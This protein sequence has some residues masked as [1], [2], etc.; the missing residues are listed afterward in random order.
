[1]HYILQIVALALMSLGFSSQL[2][3]SPWT[4]YPDRLRCEYLK[5]PL[6]IDALRPRLSWELQ[7]LSPATRSQKQTAYQIIVASTELFLKQNLGDLWDSG[8]IHSDQSIHVPYGGKP[9]LSHQVCWW[10]LR[11][12]DEVDRVSD[13]SSPSFWTMGLLR[14]EEWKARWIGFDGGEKPMEFNEL[15]RASWIRHPGSRLGSHSAGS[16]NLFP[17]SVRDPKRQNSHSA[18]LRHGRSRQFQSLCQ[19]P[20]VNFGFD[21]KSVEFS[22]WSKIVD[23]L[24]FKENWG[25]VVEINVLQ[26]GTNVLAVA[27]R[28]PKSASQSSAGLI[29]ALRIEFSNGEPMIVSTDSNWKSSDHEVAGWQDKTFNDSKWVPAQQLGAYGMEPWGEM[30]SEFRRLPARMLRREFVLEKKI[31]AGYG[32]RFGAGV[33]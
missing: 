11:V 23:L 31:Q 24:A 4:L 5:D 30:R 28:N 32:I 29:G 26:P 20:G 27:L 9:L 15:S 2:G 25:Q 14:P 19:W 18:T 10:K 16:Q 22:Q 13:W 8:K 17:T 6:G 21:R 33:L 1:M 7:S 3:A 12:W